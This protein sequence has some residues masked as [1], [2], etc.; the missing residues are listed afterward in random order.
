[1]RP[2]GSLAGLGIGALLLIALG[3]LI[4]FSEDVSPPLQRGAPAPDFSLPLLGEDGRPGAEISLASLTD[5]VVLVNFWATWCKPCEDEIPAMER[6]YQ[7]LSGDAFE[8]VAISVDEDSEPV[9]K[10]RERLGMH[11]PIALDP[12]QNASRAYQTTGY[13]ESILVDRGGEM[14]ERYVGPRPWDEPRFEDRIRRLLRG[15]R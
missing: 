6:L 2:G 9:A 10:F 5:K 1:V 3:A 13:P 7:S 15:E 4:L 8:L 12:T 14:I 11:F